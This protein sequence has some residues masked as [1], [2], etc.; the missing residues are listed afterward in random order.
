MT[1]RNDREEST[2]PIC[3]NLSSLPFFLFLVHGRNDGTKKTRESPNRRWGKKHKWFTHVRDK[4]FENCHRVAKTVRITYIRIYSNVLVTGRATNI[5]PTSHKPFFLFFRSPFSPLPVVYNPIWHTHLALIL[6]PRSSSTSSSSASSSSTSSSSLLTH[7]P[8]RSNTP[9]SKILGSSGGRVNAD[10]SGWETQAATDG[11]EYAERIRCELTRNETLSIYSPLSSFRRLSPKTHL[12]PK[13]QIPRPLLQ[14][15][16]PLR[17][18]EE[19]EEEEEE[20]VLRRPSE[21][22]RFRKEDWTQRGRH[23]FSFFSFS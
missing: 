22:S 12:S 10:S 20:G 11:D 4:F 8:F 21:K 7:R 2:C 15:P 17:E 23:S 13:I 16:S 6:F 1:K 18:E 5:S 14:P 19:V 3:G 9:G